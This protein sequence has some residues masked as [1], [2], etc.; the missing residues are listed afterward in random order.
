MNIISSARAAVALT[1]LVSV[2]FSVRA[3]DKEVTVFNKADAVTL[4]GTLSTPADGA[5]PKAVIVMATGSGQQNRDEEIMGHKPFKVIADHLA[6][7]GYAVLRMD[8]R[9]I[10]GSTGD[11]SKATTDDFVRDIAAG[12]AYA[13]SCFSGLPVGVIGHSEGGTVAIR[14][15]ASNP[16]CGFIVTLAAPAWAGDSVIMSQSR[17]MAVSML[18]RWDNEALQRSLLDIAKSDMPDT[19]A[20]MLIYMTLSQSIGDAVSIPAVQQQ[21]AAQTK[22]VLS[23]WY[24]AMLRYDPSDDMA[25]INKPWLALNGELDMQVLPGNLTTVSEKNP[26]AITKLLPGHNHLFQRCKTGMVQEY[27]TIQE[28]IS[29]ETLDVV[30]RWLDGIFG[31]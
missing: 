13:D 16:K 2:A 17:A 24:R 10:G 9:G 6:A 20:N 14:N 15:A 19:Q 11:F 30:T 12:I 18:G 1:T 7:N 3:V 23:P 31:R 21:L 5:R 29:P 28:D 4:A 22:A 27:A 8:D 26:G 25:R